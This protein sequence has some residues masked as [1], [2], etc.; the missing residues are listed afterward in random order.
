MLSWNRSGD[1]ALGADQ[2]KKSPVLLGMGGIC[3]DIRYPCPL[4]AF[5]PS[6]GYSSPTPSSSPSC[7]AQAAAATSVQAPRLCTRTG[8]GR[9]ES[10][11]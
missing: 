1:G 11:G 3:A 9:R 5:Y 6:S 10:G 2:L 7:T 8:T 4:T